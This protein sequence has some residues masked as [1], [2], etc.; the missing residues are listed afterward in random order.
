MV[1]R[2]YPQLAQL[3]VVVARKKLV[4]IYYH[5]ADPNISETAWVCGLSCH[6]VRKWLGRFFTEGQAKLKDY[7]DGHITCLVRPQMKLKGWWLASVIENNASSHLC[8]R[9]LGPDNVRHCS[10]SSCCLSL[11]EKYFYGAIL[12]SRRIELVM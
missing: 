4:E 10:R 8:Y 7:P 9:K 2:E 12:I 1:N 6:T 3:D 11:E 5:Q